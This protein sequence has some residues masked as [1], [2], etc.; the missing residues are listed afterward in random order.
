MKRGKQGLLFHSVIIYD[1]SCILPYVD[2]WCCWF[3]H[4]IAVATVLQGDT[5]DSGHC[6]VISL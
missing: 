6:M 4:S 2:L 5:A 3:A 1:L